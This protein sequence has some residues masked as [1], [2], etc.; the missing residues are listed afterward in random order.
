MQKKESYRHLLPHFQQAG[1]SYF[2]TWS[3]KD[4]VPA[5]ALISYTNQLAALKADIDIAKANKAEPKVIEEMLFTYRITRKRYLKTFDDLLD[6]EHKQRINLSLTP[7]TK[8]IKDTLLYFEGTRIENYALCIMPN[9]IHW[10]F[11]TFETDTD[12]NPVY[13]QDI[14]QSVKRFSANHINDALEIKGTLWQKESFDTTIRDRKH[15]HNAI[16][17]TLNNPVKAG[18][19]KDRKEWLGNWCIDWI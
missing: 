19:V 14:L 8:I 6:L 4:A 1:Q 15:L 2:V 17:Y 3:L 18:I 12:G 7:L 13:L 16:E 11:R 5:K 10:V 9:H